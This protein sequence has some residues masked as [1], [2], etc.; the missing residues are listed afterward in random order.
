M[1]LRVSYLFAGVFLSSE[2]YGTSVD[3]NRPCSEDRLV[4]TCTT[5][6]V[7]TWTIGTISIATYISGQGTTFV[8]AT[9]MHAFL[10]GIVANLTN[11]GETFLT[12]TLTIS[13]AGT[14]GDMPE[15]VCE[16]LSGIRNGTILRPVGEIA[17]IE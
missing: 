8:G 9:R 10:P 13:S 7:L 14:V 1:Y 16:G 5:S 4:Y 6:G 15:I 2:V 3:P 11:V 17:T 12:S